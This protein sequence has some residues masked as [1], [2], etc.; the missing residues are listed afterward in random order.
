MEKC[1][2]FVSRYFWNAGTGSCPWSLN[3]LWTRIQGQFPV[4]WFTADLGTRDRNLVSGN[5]K[6]QSERKFPRSCKRVPDK[7]DGRALVEGLKELIWVWRA[8]KF[9]CEVWPEGATFIKCQ[10]EGCTICNIHY[11]VLKTLQVRIRTTPPD[12]LSSVKKIKT[13][14]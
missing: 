5:I 14:I 9:V 4:S 10:N 6:E 12:V 7:V 8:R 1:G 2:L 3:R 11:F 13:S